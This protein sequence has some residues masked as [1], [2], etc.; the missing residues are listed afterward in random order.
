MNN[1]S[2]NLWKYQYPDIKSRNYLGIF[3]AF[4]RISTWPS[5]KYSNIL[6]SYRRRAMT[7][8]PRLVVRQSSKHHRDVCQQGGALV[9][10]RHLAL[11]FHWWLADAANV[12]WKHWPLEHIK[13]RQYAL[14]VLLTCWRTRE[15]DLLNTRILFVRLM[16]PELPG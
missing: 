2:N 11:V 6:S 1:K 8:F 14:N 15:E 7:S 3:V 5:L 13:T 10:L 12:W 16:M 9:V 4:L